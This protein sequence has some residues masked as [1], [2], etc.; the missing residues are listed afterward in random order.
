MEYILQLE[1][2]E[3]Y[4]YLAVGI[5]FLVFLFFA[6]FKIM[7]FMGLIFFSLFLLLLT[8]MPVFIDKYRFLLFSLSFILLYFENFLIFIGL[9]V[10]IACLYFLFKLKEPV[11]DFWPIIIAIAFI[12]FILISASWYNPGLQNLYRELRFYIVQVFT[13][14][15]SI[16]YFKKCSS[17][18]FFNF[19]NFLVTGNSLVALF[20]RFTGIGLFYDGGLARISGLYAH[21]NS[22]GIVLNIFIPVIVYMIFA[23]KN[24]KLS[25]FWKISLII[26]I[27]TLFLTFSKTSI[28]LLLL[29]FGIFFLLFP[30][31][32]KLKFGFSILGV[33]AAFLFVNYTFQLNIIDS[34]IY[35]LNNTGSWE[36]RVN[37]WQEIS[38]GINFMTYIRGNGAISCQNYMQILSPG[39]NVYN[40]HNVYL[41][42]FFNYGIWSSLYYFPFVY[43]LVGFFKS[44]LKKQYLYL[45]PFAIIVAILISMVSSPAAGSRFPFL[46][47][48]V[49]LI[50][51][52]IRQKYGWID[53]ENYKEFSFSGLKKYES[54]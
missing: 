15:L 9:I 48:W 37:F 27:I 23:L 42:K 45:F 7:G 24:H 35:R 46:I 43:L 32:T 34:V 49:V 54:K 29:T 4:G 47:S 6:S 2:K 39:N 51:F 12:I 41:E 13:M 28:F 26:N 14:V 17:I 44:I 8:L 5:V 52:Y 30:F 18:T 11:K 3:R 22:L 31:K 38:R 16:Y 10:P 36:W 21:P 40:P 53:E 50:A 20:Q 33:T 25:N 1:K 19:L